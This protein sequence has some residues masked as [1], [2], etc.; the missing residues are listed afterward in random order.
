MK[1]ERDLKRST[2]FIDNAVGDRDFCPSVNKLDIKDNCTLGD[3]NACI[4]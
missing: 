1:L 3:L 2:I 4:E